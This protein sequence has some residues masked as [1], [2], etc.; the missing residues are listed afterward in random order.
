MCVARTFFL[1]GIR[2]ARDAFQIFVTELLCSQDQ[3][4]VS[5]SD[6]RNPQIT[7][8]SALLLHLLIPSSILTQ[9]S[10]FSNS[11]MIYYLLSGKLNFTYLLTPQRPLISLIILPLSF[12]YFLFI[13]SLFEINS[14][15]CISAYHYLLMTFL[16][17]K[18]LDADWTPQSIPY[19]SGSE[20]VSLDVRGSTSQGQ[21]FGLPPNDDSLWSCCWKCRIFPS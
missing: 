12:L 11:E 17:T 5:H 18:L 21:D 4:C 1:S 2:Y 20:N 6:A 10:H 7:L 16:L 14:T 15:I 8:P 3:R 9:F 13:S 19:Q